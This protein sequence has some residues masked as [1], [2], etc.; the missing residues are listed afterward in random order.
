MATVLPDEEAIREAVAEARAFL[1][2][3]GA[4]SLLARL[5]AVERES[6]PAGAGSSA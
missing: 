2:H 5:D 3:I 1:E 6:S 4:V